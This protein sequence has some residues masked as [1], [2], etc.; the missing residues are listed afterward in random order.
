MAAALRLFVGNGFHGTPTSKIAKEAGVAN[1]TLFHY[2]KTKEELI[3]SLY[4]DIKKRMGASI[5]EKAA[6]ATNPK[7]RFRIQ[8]TQVVL[9]AI[10]NRDEFH[11]LQQF[12]NSPFAALLSPEDIKQQLSKS[13]HEI[14]EAIKGELIKE[15]NP[16]FILSLMSSH[17][18]G[19]SQYLMKNKFTKKE[20]EKII[21]DGFAMLWAMLA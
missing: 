21:A 16:E 3:V 4:L 7:E 13:C 20:Q 1:G 15:R 6:A 10:D 8:F 12:S 18:Y 14:E 11:Y 9:W 19:L 17:V 2:Y 5:E